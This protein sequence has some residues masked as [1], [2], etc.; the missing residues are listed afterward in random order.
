MR[1]SKKTYFGNKNKKF[2]NDLTVEITENVTKLL[3][4]VDMIKYRSEAYSQGRQLHQ[5]MRLRGRSPGR[6]HG[7]KTSSR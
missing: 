2:A 4:A 3:I 5:Q 7:Q 6:I 1:I